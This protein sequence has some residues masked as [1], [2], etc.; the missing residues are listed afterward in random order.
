MSTSF[1]VTQIQQQLTQATSV[2]ITAIVNYRTA[3]ADFYRATGTLLPQLGVEIEDRDPAPRRF[4]FSPTKQEQTY[5][6]Q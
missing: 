3:I 4:A 1:E 2:E 6:K 5:E